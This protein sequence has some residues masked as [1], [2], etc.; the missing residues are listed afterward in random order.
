MES[1]TDQELVVRSEADEQPSIIGAQTKS[2]WRNLAEIVVMLGILIVLL[3][4]LTV[5]AELSGVGMTPTLSQGQNLLASRVTYALFMPERGDVVVMRDPLNPNRLVVRRVVGLP[6][7]RL[8]LRGRQVLINDQP[9]TEE[10]IGNNLAVSDNLT[11]SAQLALTANEYYVL[12]DNRLTINDSRSWG[13]VKSDSIL[14]RAW[15]SYWPPESIGFI[16][17]AR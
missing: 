6:G 2:A 1:S 16:E 7:E 15:F 9:L 17:H 12:G 8:E 3:N 4:V 14:G 10:Y 5:N 13:P 11:A